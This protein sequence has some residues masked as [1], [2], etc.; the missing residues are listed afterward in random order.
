M[1]TLGLALAFFLCSTTV[2]AGGFSGSITFREQG[3]QDTYEVHVNSGKVISGWAGSKGN[4]K[5][6]IVGGWFDGE[7]LVFLYQKVG[8]DISSRWFSGARHMRK[9]GNAFYIE[10]D[11]SG[12]KQIMTSHPKPYEII[13]MQ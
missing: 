1:K 4:P 13:E 12:Y 3:G 6:Q 9:K 10:Y 7:R 8:M 11:L 5:Y 2:F